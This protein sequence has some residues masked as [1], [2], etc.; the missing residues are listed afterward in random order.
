MAPPSFDIYSDFDKNFRRQLYNQT[1]S[2]FTGTLKKISTNDDFNKKLKE[3]D[4]KLKKTT[5]ANKIQL[6]GDICQFTNTGMNYSENDASICYD[7]YINKVIDN[8][9]A[10]DLTPFNDRLNTLKKNIENKFNDYELLYKLT[11]NNE[12]IFD[13]LKT[14]HT[15][16]EN[17][18]DETKNNINK[19]R[20][21][22]NIVD[23]NIKSSSLNRINSI[24]YIANI[25]L[26]IVTVLLGLYILYK[27]KKEYI[28]SL[29]QKK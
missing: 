13:A 16:M 22:K 12:T 10:K 18:L 21:N 27:N 11:N 8:Q 17:E 1:K 5:F 19:E 14:L 7:N 20:H 2:L 24:M 4:E 9:V 28:D 3:L 6:N 25:T 15:N 23:N 29:I 26:L